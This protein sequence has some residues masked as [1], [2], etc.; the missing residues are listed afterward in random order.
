MGTK[1]FGRGRVKYCDFCIHSNL[2]NSLSCILVCLNV[3]PIINSSI[4][5][6]GFKC[7][8]PILWYLRAQN[9]VGGNYGPVQKYGK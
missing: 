8:F 4:G 3:K 1:R 7:I 6:G 2:L 5:G 9:H